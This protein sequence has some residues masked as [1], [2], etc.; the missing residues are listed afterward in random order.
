MSG[1][2]NGAVSARLALED[3]AIFVGQSFGAVREGEG[4]VVFNT[5]HTGYQEIATDPSY[6]GQI[7]VLTASQIGNTG[8][9]ARD[10][11]AGRMAL[12]GLVVRD[13]GHVA[14]SWR[15]ESSLDEALR[16]A[17]VPAIA[18]VDTRAITLRLR[19]K[20]ALRGILT[21]RPERELSD[22]A[23]VKRVL[24]TPGLLGRDLIAEVACTAPFAWDTPTFYGQPA[25]SVGEVIVYDFGVKRSILAQ[26]VDVGFRVQV[27]PPST[28]AGDVIAARPAGVLLSNG[29]GDPAV[30]HEAAENARQLLAS[31][32]P[33]V[34]VCLGHQIL[35]HAIGGKTYKLKFGHHG[36]NQPVVELATGRVEITAQ[37]HGFAVDPASLDGRAEVTHLN[38]NDRTV[39]GLRIPGKNCFAVQH[40]PEAG[41]GPN[42]ST[43]LFRRFAQM[44]KDAR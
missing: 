4:E 13:L 38:L 5:S 17:G 1:A 21:T 15:S 37:N 7:V 31:G 29:P 43:H 24:G 39:E 14:S 9:N 8:W 18:G 30:L 20:G 41:P 40:H 6:R 22:E 2:T 35:G 16:Q 26:L 10:W 34:G 33:L 32:L 23:L 42:D 19:D 44:V 25:P 28:P 3:G 27:V 36:G 12:S 11:E